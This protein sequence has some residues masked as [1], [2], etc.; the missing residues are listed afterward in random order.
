MVSQYKAK[1]GG[2]GTGIGVVVMFRPLLMM[3]VQ[4]NT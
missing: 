3:K 4:R 2:L 1:D